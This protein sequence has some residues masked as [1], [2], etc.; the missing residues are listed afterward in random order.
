MSLIA[1]I[2]NDMEKGAVRLITEYRARLLCDAVRLCES[3]SDAE[4]LVSRTLVKVIGNIDTLKEDGSL[5]NWMKSIMVNLHRNDLAHPV[6]RGTVPVNHETLVE[7]AGADWSTDEEI[8]RNSDGEAVRAALRNLDPE[9][10]EILILRYYEDLSLKEIA[11]FLNKPVGTIGRRIHIALKLLAG[12]LGAKMNKT[13]KPLA[14]ILVAFVSLVSA[15]AVATLPAF[16]PLRATVA[17][18]F[19]S[20]A[21]QEE[22]IRGGGV[23][24]AQAEG[25]LQKTQSQEAKAEENQN[26]KLTPTLIAAAAASTVLSMNV[27]AAE[28]PTPQSMVNA[29]LATGENAPASDLSPKLYVQNGLVAFWDA[30]CNATNENGELVHDN[31]TRT[32]CDLVAGR[33]YTLNAPV[34]WKDNQIVFSGAA[35]CWATLSAAD[36][37]TAYAP[38]SDGTL[39]V[40][41]SGYPQ[42]IS[43]QGPALIQYTAGYPHCVFP[44]QGADS[45]TKPAFFVFNGASTAAPVVTNTYCIRYQGNVA[46]AAFVRGEAARFSPAGVRKTNESGSQIGALAFNNRGTGSFFAIRTYSRPLSKDEMAWNVALDRARYF[47]DPLPSGY[48]IEGGKAQVKLDV[49][50]NEEFSIDGGASWQTAAAVWMD[51]G[52]TVVLKVRKSGGRKTIV[53][54]GLHDEDVVSADADELA[55]A[56]LHLHSPRVVAAETIAPDRVWTAS[57]G[58]WSVPGNWSPAGVPQE[59]EFV[60][61]PSSAD[62]GTSVSIT[63][64][65]ANVV[66]GR[67]VVGS[68]NPKGRVV[69]FAHQALALTQSATFSTGSTVTRAN[70]GTIKISVT[71]DLTVG[72][73]VIFDVQGRGTGTDDVWGYSSRHGGESRDMSTPDRLRLCYGSI[74]CPTAT[75]KGS[76]AGNGGGV[77]L[78]TAGGT[79]R[80]DG[81]LNADGKENTNG[82]SYSPAGGSIWVTAGKL[83]GSGSLTTSGGIK[84]AGG[85]VGRGPG[86]RLAAHLT[87]EG[88]TFA[89]FAGMFECD[90]AGP[91]TMYFRL[92][93]QALDEGELVVEQKTFTGGYTDITKDVTGT[94]VGK[95]TVKGKPRIDVIGENVTLTCRGDWYSE[96]SMTLRNGGAFIFD[97]VSTATI[98][99]SCVFPSFVCNAPGKTLKFGTAETDVFAIGD[100]GTLTLTGAEGNPMTLVGEPESAVWKVNV[101]ANVIQSNAY[102][103]VTNSDASGGAT[104][105]ASKSSGCNCTNWKFPRDIVPGETNVWTGALNADFVSAANWSLERA[106][107]STDAL[108]IRGNAV[109]MPVCAVPTAAFASLELEPGANL[110][111]SSESFA[112][113]D[114]LTIPSGSA[115]TMTAGDLLVGGRAQIAGSLSCA[116][117]KSVAFSNDVSFANGQFSANGGRFVLVGTNDR[118]V[119]PPT[120]FSALRIETSGGTVSFTKGFAADSITCVSTEAG[121]VV[122]ASG[123]SVTVRT[124]VFDGRQGQI[125]LAGTSGERWI[126]DATSDAL[127]FLNVAVSGAASSGRTIYADAGSVNGGNNDAHW[128]FNANSIWVGNGD[129]VRFSDPQNW[130]GQSVPG[131]DARVALADAGLEV[132]IDEPVTI[133]DLVIGGGDGVTTLRCDT[134]MTVTG[135]VD[136]RANGVLTANKPISVGGDV[137]LRTGAKMTHTALPG[138][139]DT[140]AQARY[141]IDVSVRGDMTLEQGAVIEA[142]GLGYSAN[143]GPGRVADLRLQYNYRG[144]ASHGGFGSGA[145]PCYGSVFRPTTCGSGSSSSS[146]GGAIKLAV[147]GTLTLGGDVLAQP[148][149]NSFGCE[150]GAAGSIW[151]DCQNLAGGGTISARGVHS[152]TYAGGGGGRIA[153]YIHGEDAYTGLMEAGGSESGDHDK[154]GGAGTIY[155]QLPGEEDSA[156]TIVVDNTYGSGPAGNLLRCKETQLPMAADGK[157]SKAYQKATLVVQKRAKV[158]LMQSM[159]V[160]DLDMRDDSILD[161]GTNTLTIL[162]KKHRDREGWSSLAKVVCT[163]NEATGA[164]GKLVW[165]PSGFL[166]SIH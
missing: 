124:V 138:S 93:G 61:I 34:V 92:P 49:A 145:L 88:S 144:A 30:I 68:G 153:V 33:P 29:P 37:V 8:L 136:V 152:S 140:E 109:N 36:S 99:G 3:T 32:W 142:S 108:L 112:V 159:R 161:L 35:S 60:Y 82:A 50:A 6:A 25:E 86:G 143:H 51:L 11:S 63:A 90:G 39:D 62:V 4:D 128:I 58:N 100:N 67:L 13:R 73:G 77:I 5:Y 15:A 102:L 17:G 130:F 53:W 157:P 94:R 9:D 41:V 43:S 98:G 118:Q 133:G 134:N 18:W 151:I 135:S 71:N 7:C 83:I 74:P 123:E 166:I 154:S 132:L 129:G 56:T 95:I 70:S 101:G 155:R 2:H 149:V 38:A 87:G 54:D 42:L 113:R 47:G 127:S 165:R 23:S 125:S 97:P 147:L 31:V 126:L 91:G 81:W 75:G 16:E 80:I 27:A 163:T 137:T 105:E 164:Y 148:G 131:A 146:G 69:L 84:S 28:T 150:S 20:D 106:P 139:A 116:A 115:L 160:K 114:F 156:G 110:G 26:M 78:L 85:F 141:K 14:V 64:N 121:G 120:A 44:V 46:T 1:D 122:F 10:R 103:V 119:N 89:D 19:G 72:A 21:A 96:G 52:S 79:M 76:N 48:R 22:D 45:A 162:S 104:V 59:G 117:G 55:E 40:C 111:I 107:V 57:G 24:P 66:L 158:R 12:K 65:V